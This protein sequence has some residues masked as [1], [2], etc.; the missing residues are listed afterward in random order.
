MA[1]ILLGIWAAIAAGDVV[2]L[3]DDA[4]LGDDG[5]SWATA[6]KYLQDAL[7]AATPGDEIWVAAGTYKPDDD[8]I[9]EDL[10]ASSYTYGIALDVAGG[11]MYW[12]DWRTDK[13]RRANLD[14]SAVEDLVAG[15]TTP[16]GIALDVAGGKMYWT[17]RGTDKIQHA[18]LDGSNMQDL[19][20]GSPSDPNDPN[21]PEGIALDVSGGKMYWTDWG[22]HKIQRANLDGS[23]VENL[24]TALGNPC[25]IA[26]D[27][28]G[29]K[30]YWTDKSTDKIQRANLDGSAVENL[31]TGYDPSGIALDLAAGKMY[32]TE[33]GS[34]KIRRANM[35]PGSYGETLVTTDLTDPQGIALDVAASKMYWTNSGSNKIQRWNTSYGIGTRTATFQ[36]KNGVAVYG[37]FAGCETCL[38]GRDWQ[39]NKTILSGNIGLVRDKWD[40]SYHVV[41]GSG[42]N[43]TAI[44]DGFTITGGYAGGASY[45]SDHGAGM[46]NESGSPKVTNCTLIGNSAPGGLGSGAG[47][48]N[49]YYSAPMLTNCTFSGNSCKWGGGGMA[50][51]NGSSPMLINCTFSGNSAG[52]HGG[53]MAN[54]IS[55]EPNLTNC[56]FSGNQADDYGGA[57]NNAANCEPELTNCILWGNTAGID[58]NEVALRAEPG[59]LSSRI[60]VSYSNIEGGPNGV[61]DPCSTLNWGEGNIDEDA[62]LVDTDG[63]DSIV[64]T[65]DD[66]LRLSPVSPC[67]DAGDNTAVP[68]DTAD[69]DGDG[70]TT[71]P[72][73][74]D[75]DGF[76]RFIDDLCIDDT[77][78]GD[79]PI[80]DMGACEFLRS[81]IDRNGALDFVDFAMFALRWLETGCGECGGA[82]LTCDG[83]VDF[84]DLQE[85]VANWLAGGR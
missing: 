41:T 19:V 25:G 39:T 40:N 57:I 80:V 32:W 45:P 6:Y 55:C 63:P 71:E 83:D 1:V 26:L 59:Y 4:P 37:G 82:E 35:S 56:T 10:V 70:N 20:A 44:L 18:N 2:Y 47:M 30:M 67:I 9:P 29:G 84:N 53:G 13:I 54:W 12:T 66:N 78:N 65:E 64:G 21:D 22:I 51:G 3:D 58:G 42:T 68:T 52:N 73:P 28:A 16:A 60:R 38:D 74:R 34:S 79:P 49:G 76:P 33:E 43:A 27:V 69:V 8:R 17:N 11:K 75:I 72:T 61:H 15:L 31:A 14:G 5:K 81:N 7:A 48:F 36:L 23:A 46:F 85:F 62:C 24:V 50:N 77:G